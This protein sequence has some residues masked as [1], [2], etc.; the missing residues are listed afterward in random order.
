MDDALPWFENVLRVSYYFLRVSFNELLRFD[1]LSRQ[2][3]N[4]LCIFDNA[5]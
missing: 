4:I 1:E 5:L 3:V 2:F